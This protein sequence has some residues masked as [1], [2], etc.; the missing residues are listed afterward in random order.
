MNARQLAGSSV[1][2]VAYA[3]HAITLAATVLLAGCVQPTHDR[4]V[5]YEVD[6]S[7][8]ADVRTVGVRGSDQ[9]LTWDGDRA[10]DAVQPGALYRTAVTYRTGYLVTRAKFTV[11]GEFELADGD[12]RVIRFA[13]T[14]DTTWYRAVF[15]VP[16]P[17]SAP[18]R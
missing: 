4:T 9:P 15:D 11:N 10:L 12:N 18:A 2:R 7:R 14:G 16:R 8:V 1:E 17:D 13:T 3:R 5:V 6:V